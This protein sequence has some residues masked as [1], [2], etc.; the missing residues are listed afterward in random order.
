MFVSQSKKCKTLDEFRAGTQELDCVL[1]S[2][3]NTLR[4]GSM[5]SDDWLCFGYLAG[6]RSVADNNTPQGYFFTESSAA[7]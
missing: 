7:E 2:R 6:H 1:G 3:V 4:L 5:H